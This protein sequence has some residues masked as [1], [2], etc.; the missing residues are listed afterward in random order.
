MDFTSLIV[1]GVSAL[2]A[3]QEVVGTRLLAAN[4]FATFALLLLMGVVVGVRL[5]TNLGIPGWATST[6]GLLLILVSQALVASIML[7]FSIMMNRSNLGFL[8]V[9]DY[10]YFISRETTIFSR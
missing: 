3:N 9:R 5:L 6:M 4:M 8:P 10:P 2:F 7:I 1:H